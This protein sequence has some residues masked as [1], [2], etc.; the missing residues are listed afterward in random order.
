MK[1]IGKITHKNH[2]DWW[3][4]CEEGLSPLVCTQLSFGAV[5]KRDPLPHLYLVVL[6]VP[7]ILEGLVNRDNLGTQ[8]SPWHPFLGGLVPLYFLS[9][10]AIQGLL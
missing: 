3:L 8:E 7:A 5:H 4:S 10:L 9:S 1:T 6:E 2:T